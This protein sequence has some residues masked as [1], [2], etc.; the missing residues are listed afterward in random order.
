M[1]PVTAYSIMQWYNTFYN[2]LPVLGNINES[3][4]GVLVTQHNQP[5]PYYQLSGNI[6]VVNFFFTNCPVICVRMMNNVKKVQQA[7]SGDPNV[8]FLSV[9]VDPDRDVPERLKEYSKKMKIDDHS[10]QLLT[11]EKRAIYSIARNDFK[12]VAAA[13]DKEE[14]DFIHSEKL[15]LVDRKGQIRGYYNGT[16]RNEID[17]LINDINKLKHESPDFNAR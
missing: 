3:N 12:L 10:W 1:L 2:R 16:D 6:A 4:I 17:K 13:A 7:Y 11:G 14:E 15:V 5:F 9:T 8:H